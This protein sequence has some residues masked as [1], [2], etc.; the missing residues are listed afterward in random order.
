M[1]YIT[2]LTGITIILDLLRDVVLWPNR[3][4]YYVD[5]DA[6]F[7][8]SVNANIAQQI[9]SAE[10]E[11][12]DLF[13]GCLG[14]P[15]NEICETYLLV[16]I[17]DTRIKL[18]L[19][20]FLGDRKLSVGGGMYYEY[21]AELDINRQY[22]FYDGYWDEIWKRGYGVG[23]LKAVLERCCEAMFNDRLYGNAVKHAKAMDALRSLSAGESGRLE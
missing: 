20:H 5:D 14:E 10:K 13:C 9:E 18:L 7:L 22:E 1:D 16:Y 4:I 11:V 3:R 15:S 2:A 8:P 23:K 12:L 6:I 19:A 17:D 21:D